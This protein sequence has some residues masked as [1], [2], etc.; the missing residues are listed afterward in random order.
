VRLRRWRI[1]TA[2]QG[3]AG[4]NRPSQLLSCHE[5]LSSHQGSLMTALPERL[6]PEHVAWLGKQGITLR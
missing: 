5:N 4:S 3:I 1:L 6:S 2:G